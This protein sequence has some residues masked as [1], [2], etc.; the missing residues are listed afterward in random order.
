MIGEQLVQR[1]ADRANADELAVAGGLAIRR[2]DVGLGHDAAAEAHLRGFAHAQ[3]RL[4]DAANLPRQA[5]LAEHRRCRRNDAIA[6]RRRDRGHHA[7]VGR[8]FVH[9][10]AAG[11]VH[12]HIVADEVQAR[13]LFEHREQQRE[14]LLVDAAR[15]AARAPVA[16]R[17]DE[18]LDFDE[19]RARPL[20]RAQHRRPRRI[21]RPLGQEQLGRI[22]HRPQAA[23]RHLEHAELADGAEPVLHRADD[24]VRVVAFAFEVEHRV[25]D[26]LEGLGAGQ[27]AVLGDVA[28]QE[29]RDVLALRR[30][31]QLRRR[32]ADLPDAARRRLELERVDR[33]NRVDDHERR[34]DA[35]HLLEDALEARFRQQIERRLADLE[36]LTPRFDLVFRF[37]AGAVQH[38][39]DRPRHVR[40]GLEQQRGLADARFAAE[41]DERSGDDAAAE[42]AIELADARREPGVLFDL[43]VAV[44][45]RAARGR[46]RVPMS[47]R[48]R[49]PMPPAA[50]P[51]RASSTRR[52]R[53]IARAISATARRIPG[54]RRRSWVASWLGQVGRVRSGA[55]RSGQVG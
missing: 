45:A 15:H 2:I 40:G 7:Q 34:L 51:R 37:L 19:D 36:T 35:R 21:R 32:F 6:H 11:D 17:A 13:A 29:R 41:Q 52:S 12:E 14:P 28:D 49:A 38:R 31:Q 42:H 39:P 9:R 30:E 50:A 44:Q 26:V 18:R 20:D 8:R 1:F 47:G 43:D 46:Q 4:R 16:A 53:R 3:G 5:H 24:A 54:R 27:A 25:H 23:R 55:G 48:R 10:H 33:L 22:R